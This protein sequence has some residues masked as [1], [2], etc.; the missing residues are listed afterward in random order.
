MINKWKNIEKNFLLK[1][2]II[3]YIMNKLLLLPEEKKLGNMFDHPVT[4]SVRYHPFNRDVIK[5][6]KNVSFDD[7]VE[8]REEKIVEKISSSII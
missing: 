5:P 7:K 3:L 6:N 2:N 4:D 1:N 8:V